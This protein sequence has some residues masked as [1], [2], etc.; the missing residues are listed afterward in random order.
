MGST[1]VVGCSVFTYH[2]ITCELTKFTSWIKCGLT[3]SRQS[4]VLYTHGNSV[5][6]VVYS[7]LGLSFV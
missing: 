2:F 5:I 4:L 1:F 6:S 7:K 3:I